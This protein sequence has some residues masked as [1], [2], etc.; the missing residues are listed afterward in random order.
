MQ[1]TKVKFDLPVNDLMPDV[2]GQS[3]ELLKIIESSF[4][5]TKIHVRGN[6]ITI[7]ERILI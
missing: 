4:P 6:Q 1:D 7:E 5:E 2:L 3:D